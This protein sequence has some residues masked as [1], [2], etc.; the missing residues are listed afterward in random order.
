MLLRG[1]PLTSFA[2]VQ[3][4]VQI[5]KACKLTVTSHITL[6]YFLLVFISIYNS[7]L[8]VDVPPS[9]K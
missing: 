6:Q 7:S 5:T 2:E 4:I 9:L 1:K 3:I 8:A